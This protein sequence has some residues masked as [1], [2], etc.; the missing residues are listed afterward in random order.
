MKTVYTKLLIIIFSSSILLAGDF[1]SLKRNEI[2]SRYN[3]PSTKSGF[4]KNAI[5]KYLNGT[6]QARNTKLYIVLV[7]KDNYRFSYHNKSFRKY[8]IDGSYKLEIKSNSDKVKI[9][10]ISKK[11]YPRNAK[12]VPV[13]ILHNQIITIGDFEFHKE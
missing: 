6:W 8:K 4:T 1:N 9:T 13:G 2:K 7:F 5:I 3:N 10:F 11:R 12:K